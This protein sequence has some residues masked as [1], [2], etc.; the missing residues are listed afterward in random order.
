MNEKKGGSQSERNMNKISGSMVSFVNI[1]EFKAAQENKPPPSPQ[2]KTGIEGVKAVVAVA[3]GKGGVGKSTVAFQLAKSMAEAGWKVAL[4]D[5][6]VYGPS[7]ALL[8]QTGELLQK[9]ADES[10]ALPFERDGILTMSIGNLYPPEAHISWK[11]P[12]VSQAV[13]E[14]FYDV[15]WGDVDAMIVDMPPGTG[16]VVLTI[17]E[18][19]PLTGAVIVTTPQQIATLDAARGIRMFHNLNV[20]V[21]GIVENMAYL[22]CPCCGEERY[23]FGRRGG[24]ALAS[25]M[26]IRLLGRIPLDPALNDGGGLSSE[27]AGAYSELAGAVARAVEVEGFIRPEND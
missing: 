6:D 18:H 1:S 14:I 11:G 25:R 19:I 23:P 15:E 8:C 24:E 7:Q 9:N 21:L 26:H 27:A 17:L 12:I 5:V 2:P 13:L 10:K 3:S 16:D 4:A 22:Q 20:P